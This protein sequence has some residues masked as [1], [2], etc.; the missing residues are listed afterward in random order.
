MTTDS[1]ILAEEVRKLLFPSRAP[2]SFDPAA[3]WADLGELVQAMEARGCFLM[4]NSTNEPALKRMASFH[5]ATPRGFPCVGA[6]EWGP[7][8]THGA[9]ILKA[10]HAALTAPRA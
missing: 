3:S 7:F 9:A 8:S 10:A 4:T 5:K 2:G 1:R 6:S